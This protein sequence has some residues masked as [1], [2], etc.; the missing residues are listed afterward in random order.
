MLA[1]HARKST[2]L[3]AIVTAVLLL[4]STFFSPLQADAAQS[5]SQK[6][7]SYSKKLVNSPYKWGGTSPKGFDASGFTQYVFSKSVAKK[8]PRTSADQYKTG[9]SIAKNKLKAGD[10]VFYK[11]DGKKVSFVAIYI[12]N[13]KFIGATSKGVKTQSMNLDYWKKRN[14]GA[15]RVVN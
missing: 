11:T 5:K 14:G 15:K 9:T 12:G 7:V 2:I 6:A 13:N 1:L 10:L 4:L 3:L 8:L